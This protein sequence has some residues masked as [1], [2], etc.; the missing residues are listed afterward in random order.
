[1]RLHAG[2]HVTWHHLCTALLFRRPVSSI[3]PIEHGGWKDTFEVPSYCLA[4]EDVIAQ[5]VTAPW[6]TLLF[7]GERVHYLASCCC[8]NGTQ[9]ASLHPCATVPCATRQILAAQLKLTDCHPGAP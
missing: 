4:R 9:L 8:S 6:A 7:N 2:M 1:M 5:D 3:I